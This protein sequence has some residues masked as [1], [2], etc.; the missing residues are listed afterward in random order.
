MRFAAAEG[1]ETFIDFVGESVESVVLNGADARPGDPVG[2]LADRAARSRRRERARRGGHRGLHQHRRGHAP[3]RRPGRRRGLPLQ[4]VRG[5]GLASGLR[6]LRAARPQGHVRLH[7]HGA[8]PLDGP[9][10]LPHAGADARRRPRR[11]LARDVDLR[12]DPGPLLLRHRHRVR[13]LR[14][15]H[16]HRP[17]PSGPGR[18]RG[19]RTSLALRVRRL[20]QHHRPDQAGLRVLRARVRL[21]IPVREVRPDL[22]AGVQ[23]RRDGERRL[24][25]HHRDL[26]LPR[27]GA[28]ATGRAPWA[29][30]PPRA[31]AHV[32]RRPRDD[33]VVGRPLAQRVVRRMGVHPVPGRGD[34]L[35]RGV[36]H[37]PEPREDVGVPAG[38]AARR[39]TRSTPTSATS[40][41][42]SSTSTGSPTPRAARSSSSSSPTSASSRSSRGCAPT[43]RRMPGA[44]PGSPTS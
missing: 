41:T 24:R 21:G 4:P 22:H 32:V 35:D 30:H 23:R 8:R 42:S 20:R 7:R 34:P 29:D 2:R 33:A 19:V 38:P 13:A 10:R 17:E 40:T 1:S 26:R 5:A 15:R 3:F 44:T 37:V 39:R 11:D 9:V 25:D 43:S 27:Q 6:R 18:A 28:G 31:R 36:D 12:P 16:R 14:R